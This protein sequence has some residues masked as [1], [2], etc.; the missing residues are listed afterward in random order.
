MLSII[1]IGKNL[2]KIV[3]KLLRLSVGVW[4]SRGFLEDV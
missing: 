1:L 4:E 3:S 2:N